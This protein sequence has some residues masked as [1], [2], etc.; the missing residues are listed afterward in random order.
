[1]TQRIFYNCQ[2]QITVIAFSFFDGKLLQS[3]GEEGKTISYSYKMFSKSTGKLETFP[4]K[5]SKHTI[6]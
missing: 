2:S 5:Y 4:C 3:V 1:M 6:I